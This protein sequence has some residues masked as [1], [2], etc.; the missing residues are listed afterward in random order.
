MKK[1]KSLDAVTH[2]HTHTHTHTLV[3]LNNGNIFNII[4]NKS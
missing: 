3:V 2:T 1:A 4:N